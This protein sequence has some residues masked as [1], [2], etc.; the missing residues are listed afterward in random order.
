[1]A[2]EITPV[3]GCATCA[4]PLC[5]ACLGCTACRTYS[6]GCLC[7]SV[8]CSAERVAARRVWLDASKALGA[9]IDNC[10]PCALEWATPCDDG[11]ALRAAADAAWTAYEEMG[12]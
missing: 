9:H 3:V 12:R 4:A 8:E 1:M 11:Q 10:F 6:K 7:P 5:R 2:V